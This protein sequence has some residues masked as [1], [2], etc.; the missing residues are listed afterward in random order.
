MALWQIDMQMGVPFDP[1][2][3]GIYYWTEV[4]YLDPSDFPSQQAIVNKMWA[5]MAI[6]HLDVTQ[7]YRMQ[8][9]SQPGRDNV[10]Y[11]E[12][13]LN[14]YG[15]IPTGSNGYSMIN[16]SR[17]RTGYADGTRSY[18]LRRMPLRPSDMDGM[19]LS[20]SGLAQQNANL[21]ALAFGTH[22]RGLSGSPWTVCVISPR[23][24]MWQLRDGTKRR[25]RPVLQ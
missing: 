17:W 12:N 11:T 8:I 16:I 21:N 2:S 20:V 22:F 24:H 19:R 4:Y 25:N 13:H 14:D 6:T 5:V 3:S 10:I 18:K 9:K 15:H 23:V 1:N 7:T